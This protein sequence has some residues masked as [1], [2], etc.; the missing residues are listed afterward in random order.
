MSSPGQLDVA[1]V[2]PAGAPGVLDEVVGKVRSI[3]GAIAD[4]QH[5]MVQEGL[6]AETAFFIVDT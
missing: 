1:V 3:G 5:S 4:D 2:T 6:A